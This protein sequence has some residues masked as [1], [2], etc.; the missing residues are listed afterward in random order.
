MNKKSTITVSQGL[1]WWLNVTGFFRAAANQPNSIDILR[2]IK[3]SKQQIC[4]SFL[5]MRREWWQKYSENNFP[6]V[7]LPTPQKAAAAAHARSLGGVFWWRAQQWFRT[8]LLVSGFPP[9]ALQAQCTILQPFV[10]LL[11]FFFSQLSRESAGNFR[12]T[13]KA[14]PC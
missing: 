10:Y 12:H 3:S 9:G 1:M 11:F 7:K 14:S 13:L 8:T 2:I 4:F 6:S 5:W